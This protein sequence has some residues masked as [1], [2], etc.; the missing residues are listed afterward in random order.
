MIA[1]L[2]VMLTSLHQQA[3]VDGGN[4]ASHTD[5]SILHHHLKFATVYCHYISIY[6]CSTF[7]F[8]YSSDSFTFVRAIVV[9]LL[10]FNYSVLSLDF[11]LG[12]ALWGWGLLR[13]LIC[14]LYSCCGC[15]LDGVASEQGFT[16]T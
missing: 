13:C 16:W 10:N 4:A 7:C 15:D 2:L 11:R 5:H 6:T 8:V 12:L 14:V 3:G 9:T 1:M